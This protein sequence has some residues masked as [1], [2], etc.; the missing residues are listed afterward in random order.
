VL[1]AP[2]MSPSPIARVATVPLSTSPTR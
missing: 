2:P 1:V